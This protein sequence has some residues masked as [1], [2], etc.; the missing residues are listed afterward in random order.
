MIA[1]KI[2]MSGSGRSGKT[3]AAA[4]SRSSRAGLKFPVGRVHRLLRKGKYSKRVGAGASVYLAAVLEYLTSEVMELA[5]NMA[6]DSGK[7]RIIPRYLQ[8]S[9]CID[10]ELNKLLRRVT[11]PE[12]GVVPYLNPA[13][14]PK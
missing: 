12:G 5:G 14:W 10:P 11:I 6:R 8:L 9:V 2:N 7:R 13:L 3:R 1:L 4:K